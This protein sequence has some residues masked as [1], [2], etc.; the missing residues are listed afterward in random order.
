MSKLGQ[1]KIPRSDESGDFVLLL[2]KE[3]RTVLKA[4]VLVS[5]IGSSTSDTA[6]PGEFPVE[7]ALTID[8]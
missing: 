5:D 6:L 8:G 1:V 3:N 4:D 7:I 2:L